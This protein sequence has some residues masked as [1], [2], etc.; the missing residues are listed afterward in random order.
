[1]IYDVFISYSWKDKETA[2]FIYQELNRAG[3]T[4]FI[5]DKE[6]S[7]GGSFPASVAENILNSNVFLYLGSN[8]SYNSGLAPEEFTYAKNHKDRN[9]ILFYAIDN[10]P[11]PNWLD[12]ASGVLNRRNSNEHSLSIII[13]DIREMTGRQ[14]GYSPSTRASYSLT[15]SVHND[16]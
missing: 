9:K 16:E 1:M 14:S 13:Q 4:V 7:A 15:S 5:D 8:N 3:F 6:L 12:F 11:L 2:R 10:S